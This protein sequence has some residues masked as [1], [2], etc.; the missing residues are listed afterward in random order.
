MTSIKLPRLLRQRA[1]S[2]PMMQGMSC[3]LFGKS[4]TGQRLVLNFHRE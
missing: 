3:R 4:L 2:A 1:S